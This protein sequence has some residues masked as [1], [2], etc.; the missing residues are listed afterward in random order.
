[1]VDNR[2]VLYVMLYFINIL[3]CRLR[4]DSNETAFRTEN[5]CKSPKLNKIV[6]FHYSRML[7]VIISVWS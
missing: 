1:M 6:Q 7:H 3:Q 5:V 4:S 2:N